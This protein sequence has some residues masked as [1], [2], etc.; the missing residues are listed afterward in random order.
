VQ[1]VPEIKALITF[2]GTY[3]VTFSLFYLDDITRVVAQNDHLAMLNW[4]E[5]SIGAKLKAQHTHY[6]LCM[7]RGIPYLI[8]GVGRKLEALTW[9]PTCVYDVYLD[10]L[11]DPLPPYFFQKYPAVSIDMT[12]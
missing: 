1:V 9:N 10:T 3:N 6:D 8:V 12:S 7:F 5:I 11:F 4:R 2:S